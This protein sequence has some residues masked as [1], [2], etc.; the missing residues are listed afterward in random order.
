[1]IN[2]R[3]LTLNEVSRS[4]DKPSMKSPLFN[5]HPSPKFSALGPYYLADIST[6]LLANGYSVRFRA[7][8][9]SMHPAIND[10]ELI[11]VKSVMPS[12]LK[13]GDI[14]LYRLN[15]GVI[16]HRVVRILRKKDGAPSFL[17][18]GDAAEAFDYPVEVHQVL[19]KVTSVQRDG[20]SINLYSIRAKML[21]T[22]HAS[23]SRLKRWIAGISLRKW[24]AG[25]SFRK[26]IAG[27]LLR[28]K[29]KSGWHRYMKYSSIQGKKSRKQRKMKMNV[30]FN[31]KYYRLN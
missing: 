9:N 6:E 20:C 12:D 13:R 22:G 27:I 17:L 24:I 16:A 21:R 29:K 30:T 2:K 10:G 15:S 5:L 7:P 26:W 3:F 18:Q 1:M 14:V 19:G 8:G 31:K 11:I 25:I 28:N 4:V 23:A